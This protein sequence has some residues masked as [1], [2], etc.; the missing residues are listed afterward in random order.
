M[1]NPLII[2][3]ALK[4]DTHPHTGPFCYSRLK[5][6]NKDMQ[7]L[8]EGFA[9]YNK[10]ISRLCSFKYLSNKLPLSQPIKIDSYFAQCTL[11]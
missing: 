7:C 10:H 1:H 6:F 5:Q 2:L 11:K 4:P 8:L 9:Q 3:H